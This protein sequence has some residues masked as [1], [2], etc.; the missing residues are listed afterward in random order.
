M[1]INGADN[2]V[3]NYRDLAHQDFS[4]LSTSLLDKNFKGTFCVKRKSPDN[5]KL[6]ETVSNY[7]NVTQPLAHSAS[8]LQDSATA[9]RFLFQGETATK[10]DGGIK[11]NIWKSQGQNTCQKV[12]EN[13]QTLSFYASACE[14]EEELLKQKLEALNSIQKK[15]KLTIQAILFKENTQRVIVSDE[16]PTDR[17]ENSFN[18]PEECDT[19]ILLGG[20]SLP[21][22]AHREI[23]ISQSEF[24]KTVLSEF[25][26]ETT[27][28]P[29]SGKYRI[30][31]SPDY[32]FSSQAFEEVIHSFYN[33]D[34]NLLS[35]DQLVNIYAIADFLEVSSI[36]TICL[37]L[38][39]GVLNGWNALSFLNQAYLKRNTPF[40][41]EILL[42]V[43]GHAFALLGQP[44]FLSLHEELIAQI[45]VPGKVN[46]CP[47][48]LKLCEERINQFKNHSSEQSMTKIQ[49]ASNVDTGNIWRRNQLIT[50]VEK[51]LQKQD[52]QEIALNPMDAIAAFSSVISNHT[53]PL[54]AI[55][56]LDQDQV[57]ICWI[58]PMHN[59]Q[60]K[61]FSLPF[62][63]EE[64]AF[65][66]SFEDLKH[67]KQS[68]VYLHHQ[69]SQS[70]VVR[71][72]CNLLPENIGDSFVHDQVAYRKEAVSFSPLMPEQV[73]AGP[74]IIEAMENNPKYA[75]D[76]FLF[77][78]VNIKI[79]R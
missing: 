25:V 59:A 43:Q 54:Y 11:A 27:K 61:K 78:Y 55:K 50:A 52:N 68:F 1:N 16:F 32:Q 6:P 35:D 63:I 34:L 31:I 57:S 37:E 65:T 8:L 7:F 38:L 56:H 26:L 70:L 3:A 79:L 58:I 5:E 30:E 36:K 20:E 40:F 75:Q 18:K 17:L 73:L 28:D 69:S 24:F 22:Y 74:F 42:Y 67:S 23:L 48:S 13:F 44:E 9:L 39:K 19:V 49:L 33:A 46:L 47:Q 12:I 10:K 51:H 53:I 60:N 2:T 14:K 76:G 15:A 72:I 62:A 77:F 21:I 64:K 66:L 41:Q 29:I 71:S 4:N 45:L